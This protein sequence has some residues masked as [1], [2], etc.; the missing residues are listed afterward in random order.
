[1][2]FA[3]SAQDGTP[4]AKAVAAYVARHPERVPTMVR[5]GKDAKLATERAADAAIAALAGLP[6]PGS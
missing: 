6:V 4:D 1:E 2:V 5:M 3:L